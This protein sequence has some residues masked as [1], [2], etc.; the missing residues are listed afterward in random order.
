MDIQA[1]KPMKAPSE[2][3]DPFDDK[4]YVFETKYDGVRASVYCPNGN[5]FDGEV[6]C[7][8]ED[9]IT[10]FNLIQQRYNLDDPVKIAYRA[11]TIPAKAVA[12]DMLCHLGKDLTV[13]GQRLTLADRK[14]VLETIDQKFPEGS[15]II[16]YSETNDKFS[17]VTHRYP[18][19]SSFEQG[20]YIP[21]EG[22][23]LFKD[24]EDRHMEGVMAKDLR[25]LYR[26]GKRDPSWKKLKVWQKSWLNGEH[27]VVG[28]YTEGRGKRA[29]WLGNLILWELRQDGTYRQIGEAGTGFDDATLAKLTEQLNRIIIPNCP[30]LDVPKIPNGEVV[31][32]LTPIIEVRIK[33][34][35]RGGSFKEGKLRHPVYEG[36]AA[37]KEAV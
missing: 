35:E 5:V 27:F 10:D 19:I 17:D 32:W 15:R 28:G 3:V 8:R 18:E 2:S 25:G 9:G 22:C 24:A 4:N 11:K 14:M 21:E 7:F 37:V 29:G 13:T 26:P 6:C 20:F 36:I 16:T 33:Y 23:R 30:F 31:H 34:L 1:I 12:F